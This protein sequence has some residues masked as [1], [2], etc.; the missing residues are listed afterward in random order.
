M[1]RH[2]Y[3]TDG[4]Q[5]ATVYVDYANMTNAEGAAASG[6]A[7]GAISMWNEATNPS[8]APDQ[9]NY[10]IQYNFERTDDPAKADFIVKKGTALFG[11]SEINMAVYPHVITLGSNWF[12]SYE[13][14]Q[15]GKLAHEFGH[16]LG[17]G[18]PSDDP[19]S[20]CGLDDSIMQGATN[21]NCTGGTNHVTANDVAQSNLN[22][23][24]PSNCTL[25]A[26]P[27]SYGTEGDP[28]PTPMPTPLPTPEDCDYWDWWVCMQD[29][30]VWTGYP[31]CYCQYTPIV[32]DVSGNGFN[33]TDASHGV[34][35]DLNSDG[36]RELISWTAPNS[37]DSWL[38]LDV[39]GN[40][41][42]DNGKELFGNTSRFPNG[43]L[44]LAEYDKPENGGNGDGQ[45]DSRD[46]IFPSLRLWRDSNHNGVSE[47]G[48][49]HTLNELGLKVIELDYKTSRRTD[50]YGNQFRY[51]AKVK[52]THD[53]QLGRWAWDVILTVSH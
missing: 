18:H 14:N 36:K 2:G 25:T 38:A 24:S 7:D 3:G 41:N 31:D 21:T 53:A 37:D 34:Q 33:L 4:R 17:I 15:I 32:I 29:H 48:E 28:T 6:A 9:S 49:L 42:I 5:I 35:F 43:F 13:E 12:N 44:A 45:I 40:G 51:R 46:T 1:A 20:S 39:N 8:V 30:A 27:T 11:C 22:L 52:D 50:Q 47:P 19:N 23:T 16:R 26:P 10:K